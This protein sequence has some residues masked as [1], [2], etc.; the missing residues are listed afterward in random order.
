MKIYFIRHGQTDWNKA[1]KFQ[2]RTD[3][4]LNEEGRAV[5]LL[6][7]K[8]MEKI[9]FEA[10]FTSPLKR[11]K[12]TAE[13]VLGDRDIPVIEDE[14]LIEISF[15]VEEG[16]KMDRTVENIYH[17]FSV[18]EKYIPPQKGESFQEVRARAKSFLDELF[19]DERYQDSTVLVSTHGAT[20]SGILSV[21][22]GNPVE[23]YWAGGLHKNCGV[24]I[25]EV[26]DGIPE[27]LQEA[28]VLY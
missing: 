4:P 22:K 3:I 2:G 20:L 24:T 5:A 6:T 7:Q 11:A 25:V 17:F 23:K 21:I 18:P 27:I 1:G 26:H 19:Q 16:D 10:V 15:G 14:R 8:A 13:L 28:I 9:P 12:E